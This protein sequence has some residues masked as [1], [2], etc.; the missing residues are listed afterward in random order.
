MAPEPRAMWCSSQICDARIQAFNKS[1][2]LSRLREIKP[3]VD[4]RDPRRPKTANSKGAR[5]EAERNASIMH[6]NTILLGK[7]S[8]ILTRQGGSQSGAPQPTYPGTLSLN[9]NF[10]RLERERIDRQNQ[11]LLKRLQYMKPSIDVASFEEHWREHARQMERRAIANLNPN[12]APQRPLSGMGPPQ[13]RRP[14]TSDGLMRARGP[15]L[16]GLPV[17]SG[18]RMSHSAGMGGPSRLETHPELEGGEE[19]IGPAEEGDA[20]AA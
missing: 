7:L 5:L 4:M 13:R 19:S 20:P 9:A 10:R 11:A 16:G 17:Y 3:Q 1:L 6:E 18:S 2:H 14:Q 12:I 8:K 15:P